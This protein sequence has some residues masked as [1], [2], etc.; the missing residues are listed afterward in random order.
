ML[1]KPALNTEQHRAFDK[2][3]GL[4]DFGPMPEKIRYVCCAQ[5]QHASHIWHSACT[6]ATCNTQPGSVMDVHAWQLAAALAVMMA[7]KISDHLPHA[8]HKCLIS[9]N[10][11]S[12]K[13]M[14]DEMPWMW[15]LEAC[16]GPTCKL[17][18]G[19]RAHHA[20]GCLAVVKR[21]VEVEG[22]TWE[23]THM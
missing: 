10:Q 18:Q 11:S 9:L 13:I 8:Y 15:L 7:G 4:H 16:F 6:L 20:A 19:M 5:V 1:P 2:F 21:R 12:Y 22:L 17:H 23:V 3:F 14:R